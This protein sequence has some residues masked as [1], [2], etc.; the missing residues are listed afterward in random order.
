VR[1]L[2]NFWRV[3]LRSVL[4]RQLSWVV[5][6]TIAKLR[7]L[8]GDH[9]TMFKPYL[10]HPHAP[11]T[12]ERKIR[13]LTDRGLNQGGGILSVEARILGRRAEQFL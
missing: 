1:T 5:A 8:L 7:M 11:G 10:T 13:R 3:Q 6:K 9:Y 12:R 4:R 2:C